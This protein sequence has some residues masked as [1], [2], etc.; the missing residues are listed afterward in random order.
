[1]RQTAQ[2][3]K[4]RGRKPCGDHPIGRH[5]QGYDNLHPSVLHQFVAMAIFGCHCV[6]WGSAV[7]DR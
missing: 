7:G 6:I 3:R 4:K 1:M 2:A 5:S